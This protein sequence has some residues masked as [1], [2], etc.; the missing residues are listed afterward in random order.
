MVVP[1][2]VAAAGVLL[3]VLGAAVEMV[4]VVV[5][6]AVDVCVVVMDVVKSVVLGLVC[7]VGVTVGAELLIIVP[8]VADDGASSVVVLA[9]IFG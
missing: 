3:V 7:V 1:V 9:E 8:A 5:G 6:D 2:V 4:S